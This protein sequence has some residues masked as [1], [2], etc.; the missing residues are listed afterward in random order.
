MG[1]VHSGFSAFGAIEGD[2]RFAPAIF[3]PKAAMVSIV[4]TYEA[5]LSELEIQKGP[6]LPLAG[7][8]NGI[9]HATA[10]LINGGLAASWVASTYKG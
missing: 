3:V 4:S 9:S 8:L 6:S 7:Y 5:L 1:K 2:H 10:L